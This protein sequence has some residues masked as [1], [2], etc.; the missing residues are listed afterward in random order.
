MDAFEMVKRV[1]EDNDCLLPIDVATQLAS[2][3]Y[4]ITGLTSSLD[5]YTLEDIL[6]RYEEIY[7]E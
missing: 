5:G 2:D 6:I 3:G 4:D 7:G 1:V